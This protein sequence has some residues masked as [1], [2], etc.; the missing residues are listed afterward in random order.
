[1]TWFKSLKRPLAGA[2]T[3]DYP[4]LFSEPLLA[5]VYRVITDNSTVICILSLYP[6]KFIAYKPSS[7]PYFAIAIRSDEGYLLH[8]INSRTLSAHSIHLSQMSSVLLVNQQIVP[9]QFKGFTFSVK[10]TYF[11]LPQIIS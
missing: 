10:N 7:L 1:M 3:Q 2:D 6:L 4:A 8:L 5:K 9:A 11:T